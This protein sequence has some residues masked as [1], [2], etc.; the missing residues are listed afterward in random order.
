MC[1]SVN[2]ELSDFD[3]GIIKILYHPNIIA[4][5]SFAESE[6]TITQLLLSDFVNL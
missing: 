5:E 3:K 1:A 2:E 6:E 4:G